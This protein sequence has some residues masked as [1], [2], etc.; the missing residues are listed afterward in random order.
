M[1]KSDKQKELDTLVKE[2][3]KKLKE[4]EAF[5]KKYKLNFSIHPAYGMGGSFYGDPA[6]FSEDGAEPGWFPSSEGC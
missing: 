5:A 1:A 6:Q 3:N 2:F 4:A